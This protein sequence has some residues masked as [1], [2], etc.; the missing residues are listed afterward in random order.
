MREMSE[1]LLSI[2][3]LHASAQGREILRGLDL[4]IRPGEVHVIMG[5]NGA[6]KSTLANVILGDPRYE[7]TEGRILFEGEDITA[8]KTDAR[9]RRGIFLSFQ[10]PEE[11]PGVSVESFLRAAKNAQTGEMQKLLP[12]RKALKAKM[13]Q[14]G[15][16]ES[17]A[18]R[19]L[20]VG[21]SGGEKKK[22][23]ILQLEMLAPKLA[24]LDETDS[25]LDID[26]VRTIAKSIGRFKSPKNA[27]LIITH[28]TRI[29]QDLPVDRVHILAQGRIV[30]TDGAQI[31]D[32]VASGGF[33]S[34]LG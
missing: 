32:E 8:E 13:E 2:Q 4:E 34:V 16:P 33:A 14:L 11:I 25:G 31:I 20:N 29:L 17:Y 12:F 21:F 27:I 3:N 6:G 28:I 5:P 23:E 19:S 26:A 15:I 22:N 18:S 9:A 7:V 1:N 24:I 30:R 10:T